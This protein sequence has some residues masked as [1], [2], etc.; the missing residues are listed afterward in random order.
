MQWHWF[1]KTNFVNAGGA[2]SKAVVFL[3]LCPVYALAG[4]SSPPG[5]GYLLLF[6]AE[7]ARGSALCQV[8]Q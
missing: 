3:W 8:G 7:G 5:H 2:R 1:Q 4:C 6:A